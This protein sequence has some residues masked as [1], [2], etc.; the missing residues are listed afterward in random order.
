VA[1]LARFL[2]SPNVGRDSPSLEDLRIAFCAE[3]SRSQ[4]QSD[5]TISL[6]GV[7]YEIPGRY[8]HLPRISV[9]YAGW[10]LSHVYM[11]D[12]RTGTMLTRLYPLDRARNADGLRRSLEPTSSDSPAETGTR[13]HDGMAPLLRKLI[14][15]YAATGLPPAYLPK[16]TSREES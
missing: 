11:I 15:D 2:E 3:S 4:R 5:S 6:A 14:E 10:D 12:G 16:S 1:P 9:R 13:P 7:R 8:R